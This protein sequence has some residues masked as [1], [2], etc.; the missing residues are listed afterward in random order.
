MFNAELLESQQLNFSIFP[1]LKSLKMLTNS[2][3]NI[4]YKKASELE[5]KLLLSYD[6]KLKK[7]ELN[8]KG[9]IV[10]VL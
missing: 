3:K 4:S 2:E 9:L 1:A 7:H 8:L 6:L 5:L 10:A